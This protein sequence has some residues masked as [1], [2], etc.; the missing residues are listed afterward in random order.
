MSSR[1]SVPVLAAILTLALGY[2]GDGIPPRGA[3]ADYPA[4]QALDGLSIGAAC[5]ST[6]NAKQIFGE[7]LDRDGY[8]A[9][10]IGVFPQE[11]QQADVSS[12]GF[13]LRSGPDML[14]AMSPA[15]VAH[16][17]YPEKPASSTKVPG[18][19]RVTDTEVIGYES[20][21]V[22]RGVYT[23][24]RT[25]VG[26]GRNPNEPPPPPP[27]ATPASFRE[28]L[29]SQALPEGY[30]SRPVGGY[31]YFRKPTKDKKA[32]YELT[33]MGKSGTATLKL[34]PPK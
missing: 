19:V 11:G 9:F 1:S 2:A 27:S 4:H 18:N 28:H 23:A 5:V 26:V 20:G 14:R 13:R 15:D 31:I 30:T 8:I 32:A 12:A 29:E 24:S 34:M 16:A 7:N 3:A 10:E 22:H 6:V 25:D 33:Y 17:V 21:P